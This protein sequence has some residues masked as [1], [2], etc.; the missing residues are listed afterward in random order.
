MFKMPIHIWNELF[1]YRLERI[2]I[3][4]KSPKR[5]W[6][7]LYS[8]KFSHHDDNLGVSIFYPFFIPVT[9]SFIPFSFSCSRISLRCCSYTRWRNASFP[10]HYIDVDHHDHSV[11]MV[12]VSATTII[13]IIWVS[14]TVK[15]LVANIV[16]TSFA[17]ILFL[18]VNNNWQKSPVLID[19]MT[20]AINQISVDWFLPLYAWVVCE[21]SQTTK[22][23]VE[24][25][26]GIQGD[27]HDSI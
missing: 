27:R 1:F 7:F 25:I 20:F 22:N 11:V 17:D 12:N 9:V 19:I 10:N 8:S 6:G 24:N 14:P 13:R 5:L 26:R 2:Y 16:T 18:S 4:Q 15:R 21:Y 23:S 3:P